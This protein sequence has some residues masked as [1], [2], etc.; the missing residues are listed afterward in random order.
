VLTTVAAL[1]VFLVVRVYFFSP[2]PSAQTSPPVDQTHAAQNAQNPADS[3]AITGA[4]TSTATTA[5]TQP[6]GVDLRLQLTQDCWL[7]ITVDGRRVVY[8]T[9]PAGT[10]KEF[11]G[12]HMITLRAGN[13]GGV[14]ATVDGQ[15]L[16]TLGGN[17]QV[18]ERAF[19]AKSIQLPATG[20]RE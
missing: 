6:K 4:A 9:L 2:S 13:A 8:E 3:T 5:G 15:P 16:G 20:A 7:S 11:R 14:I 12:A 1:L 18:Q 10:V 19:A 17:G